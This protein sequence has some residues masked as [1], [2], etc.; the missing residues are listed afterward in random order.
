MDYKDYYKILGVEKRASA[1]DIKK[2]YRRLA[3]KYHPDVNPGDKAAEAKFKEI[4]G[5]Y[6]VLSDQEKRKKYDKYGDKWEYADQIEEMQRRQSAGDFFRRAGQGAG[7]PGGGTG[8]TGSQYEGDLG[9]IFGDLGSIFR[10]RGSRPA[11]VRK[12][13][14]L[15]YPIEVSLEEA[16]NGTTRT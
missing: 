3:R 5:A 15:E 13:E 9:D 4:N 8:G 10:R 6:E 16:A 1:D 2:A 7:Y 12:G 11:A 14:P